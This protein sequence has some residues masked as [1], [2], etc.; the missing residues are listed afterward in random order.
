MSPVNAGQNNSSLTPKKWQ[1]LQVQMCAIFVTLI[2]QFQA[3][4]LVKKE[5]N[6]FTKNLFKIPERA[7]VDKIHLADLLKIHLGV[8]LDP[9]NQKSSCELE[10]VSFCSWFKDVRAKIF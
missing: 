10:N 6:F 2:L 8:E 9:Q 4:I 7:G 1:I 3:V 5:V